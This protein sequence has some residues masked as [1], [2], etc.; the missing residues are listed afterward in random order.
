MPIKS[1]KVIYLLLLTMLFIT[2]CSVN[3]VTGQNELL[4]MSKQ[5]E[6]TLSEKN[7]SPSRQAQGGDYYLDSELQ[8]YVAA[9]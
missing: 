8:S 5:Q 1:I 2:S 7:Y 3:P 9:I 6:I 4:L